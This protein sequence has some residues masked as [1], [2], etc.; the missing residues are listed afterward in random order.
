M[1]T[2]KNL[3]KFVRRAPIEFDG[4]LLYAV[5][6]LGLFGVAWDRKRLGDEVLLAAPW[7]TILVASVCWYS[8]RFFVPVFPI[9][10]V[11]AGAGL[12]YFPTWYRASTSRC[13]RGAS[14]LVFALLLLILVPQC[15]DT[16]VALGVGSTGVSVVGSDGGVADARQLPR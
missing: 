16:L 11:W 2:P 9:V 10:I 1:R 8:F 3:V 15:R 14:A 7:V 5:A 13:R 4:P 6:M 12:A